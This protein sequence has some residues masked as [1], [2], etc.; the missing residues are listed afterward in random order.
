MPVGDIIGM[1]NLQPLVDTLPVQNHDFSQLYGK[2]PGSVIPVESLMVA[3][4]CLPWFLP[5]HSI[6]D[7]VLFKTINE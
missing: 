4:P 7:H 6:N 5:G 2:N 1:S 3:S